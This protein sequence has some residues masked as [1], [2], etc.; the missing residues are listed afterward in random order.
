MATIKGV[1]IA[2]RILILAVIVLVVVLV[3]KFL[4]AGPAVKPVAN[5]IIKLRSATNPLD[6]AK[7][8]SSTDNLIK[9]MNNKEVTAQ[10]DVI[11]ECINKGCSDNKYFDFL[12]ILFT[13][14]KDKI[15][16]SDLLMNI[17]A[18]QRYWRTDEVVTFSKA[19]SYVDEEIGKSRSSTLKNK[20]KEVIECNNQCAKNNDLFLQL[21]QLV[22]T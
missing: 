6:K 14:Y 13:Q 16:Q 19:M 20:W 1:R 22:I 15:A 8:I 10:W 21:I 9:K 11:T 17:L 18:V 4:T 5:D 3:Y 2:K 7:I 12:I